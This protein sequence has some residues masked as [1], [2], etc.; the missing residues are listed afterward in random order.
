MDSSGTASHLTPGM[1]ASTAHISS[2]QAGIDELSEK[3]LTPEVLQILMT[4][5]RKNGLSETEE[6]LSKEANNLLVMSEDVSVSSTFPSSEALLS[7][8]ESLVQFVD[9]SFDFFQAEFS[10]LLFPVFAHSY[11]KLLIESSVNNAKEFFKRYCKRIPAPYE[12]LVYKLERLQTAQQAQADSYV[13]LL[14]TNSILSLKVA[15]RCHLG[16]SLEKKD[17]CN[18]YNFNNRFFEQR[19]GLA[20]G[21]RIAPLV[22]IMLLDHI[23]RNTL[24][25]EILFYKW[26]ID[27]VF[28]IGQTRTDVGS[29]LKRLNSF[30]E[31]V[32]FT[33]EEPEDDGSLPF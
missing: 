4:F 22:A 17:T 24:T 21:N 15:P 33:L 14:I 26:Y 19:R 13:Q 11:I 31:R 28:V 25:F 27:D 18:V 30:D 2:T 32:I 8:F 23:K 16:C 1:P 6:A 12:E 5:L 3:Q 10:L 9:S 20:M 29:T 7:E